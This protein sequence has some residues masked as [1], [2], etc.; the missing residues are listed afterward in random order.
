MFMKPLFFLNL[1]AGIYIYPFYMFSAHYFNLSRYFWIS[2][3]P[4]FLLTIPLALSTANLISAFSVLLHSSGWRRGWGGQGQGLSL[5][6]LLEMSAGWH[7]GPI[8]VFAEPLPAGRPH[9]AFLF[10]TSE[11]LTDVFLE[12]PHHALC[13]WHPWPRSLSPQNRNS[14]G[15]ASSLVN[16]RRLLGIVAAFSVSPHT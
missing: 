9:S 11:A 2:I 12:S 7:Q 14:V 15:R 5:G 3:L 8:A 1:N 16:S 4:F 13:Q 10:R 6:V